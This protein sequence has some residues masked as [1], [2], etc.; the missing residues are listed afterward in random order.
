MGR[1]SKIN[2]PEELEAAIDAYFLS[3]E[4]KDGADKP[5]TM[6]GLA[7][8]LGYTSRQSLADNEKKEDYSYLIKDAKA[9]IKEFWEERLAYTACTGA[10]FWLKNHDEYRDAHEIS[11]PN[12]GPIQYSDLTD[13]D[14]DRRIAELKA[15][16]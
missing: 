5:P 8:A 7:R 12:G 13:T 1:P 3:L 9:R 4:V 10:I 2:S 11:G 15:G 16:E 14:L 6:T